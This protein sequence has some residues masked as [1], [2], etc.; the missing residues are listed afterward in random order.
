MISKN[1]LICI[2]E[3]NG[4]V[5]TVVLRKLKNDGYKNVITADKKELDLINQ[6]KIFNFLEKEK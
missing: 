6:K 3:Y 1:N 4:L 5:E 2:V